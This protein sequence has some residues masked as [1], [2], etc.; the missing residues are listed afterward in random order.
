MNADHKHEV[1][2]PWAVLRQGNRG[3]T[4]FGVRRNFTSFQVSFHDFSRFPK[5]E[6]K[7]AKMKIEAKSTLA[8]CP[9]KIESWPAQNNRQSPYEV[10]LP[11]EVTS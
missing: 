5:R 8:K 7:V 11:Y 1:S 3:P 10:R 4:N 6:D 9:P 2:L